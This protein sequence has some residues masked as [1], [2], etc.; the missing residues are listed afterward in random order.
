FI[1]TLARRGYRFIA[2]VNG[3]SYPAGIAAVPRQGKSSFFVPYRIPTGCRSPIVITV[4]VWAAWRLPSRRTDVIERRLTSNSSEN[5]V[6]SAAIS[7]DS[8]YL[9]Y[10]DNTGVYLKQ[11]RTAEA[12]PV[13]LP[14]NFLARVDDWFPDGSH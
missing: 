9:A 8:K 3:S 11:I 12:H 10:A 5:S 1:E 14:P 7:P 4:L 13:P 2:P 6:S